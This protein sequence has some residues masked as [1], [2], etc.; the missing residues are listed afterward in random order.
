[1]LLTGFE[2]FGGDSSNPSGDAVRLVA[3]GWDRP[4]ILVTA[5]LPVTF[6]G[7]ARELERLID[8]HSPDVVLAT[9]LA[10]GRS[11]IAVERVALNLIDARIPDNAGAQPIDAPSVP[12]A[13][14]AHFSSLPV[15]AIV[16]DVEATGI[17]VVLSNSAGTF[18]CNHVFFVAAE[19]AASTPGCASA[20]S[21]SPGRIGSLREGSPGTGI[22]RTRSA[23]TL[24]LR[25]NAPRTTRRRSRSPTSRAPSRSRSAPP[26]T[27]HNDV[28]NSGGSLY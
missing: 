22:A 23:R 27:P 28:R 12:G 20:S 26:S 13:P 15:K 10:G 5:V 14:P 18:V 1:M 7:A 9:G 3:A 4:E 16:R 8:E 21:T 6:A 24:S 11:E 17:P 2:P 25:T 19:R